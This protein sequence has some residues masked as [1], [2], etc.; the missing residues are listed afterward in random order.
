M[1]KIGF[2]GLGVMG[3]LMAGHLS[4]KYPVIAYNRSLEKAQKWGQTYSGQATS[5]LAD[6]ADCDLVCLCV[7]KDEDVKEN[8]TQLVPL[9]KQGSIIV[10]HTTASAD[11]EIEMAAFCTQYGIEY[12]DAPV[13]GGQAGAENGVLTIMVGGDE[14]ILEKAK[15]ILSVYAKQITHMGGTGKGQ[16]AKMVNQVLLTG[17]L[18]GLAEGLALAQKGGLDIIKLRDALKEGAAGSW[19]LENRAQ[20]MA[21][22]K[23]DFG[24]AL[25]LM[26]KDLDIVENYAKKAG[27]LL[28]VTK[29]V[30]DFYDELSVGGDGRLD[31]SA[32]IKRLKVS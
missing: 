19:Q 28:P 8:I 15:P 26:R 24:F 16:I 21:E 12:L 17:I 18:Q 6:L 7:G 10:D 20:T 25:D 14:Q 23:F 13:S 4:K 9:L 30:H 1:N 5:K 29:M 22:G 3:F 2:I 31:T 27:V 11:I 32:L